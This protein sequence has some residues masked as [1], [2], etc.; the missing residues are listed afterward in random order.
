MNSGHHLNID[1][2]KNLFDAINKMDLKSIT[3]LLKTK[4]IDLKK[5]FISHRHIWRN[6]IPTQGWGDST[7]SP[8][9]TSI[10]EFYKEHSLKFTIVQSLFKIALANKQYNLKLLYKILKQLI[11]HDP[12]C[13]IQP[14]TMGNSVFYYFRQLSNIKRDQQQLMNQMGQTLSHHYRICLFH[15]AITYACSIHDKG[16]P[17][18]KLPEDIIYL[19]LYTLND[20]IKYLEKSGHDYRDELYKSFN[21]V[22]KG[23]ECSI[24]PFNH[25]QGVEI[26]KFMWIPDFRIALFALFHLGQ[27][28]KYHFDFPYTD[29][30][31]KKLCEL[32]NQPINAVYLLQI[33]DKTWELNGSDY[34][35][36]L[37]IRHFIDDWECVNLK[38]LENYSPNLCHVFFLAD[39]H[40]RPY[41]LELKASEL[42]QKN[43]ALTVLQTMIQVAYQ[44]KGK[45]ESLENYLKTVIHYF[46]QHHPSSLTERD[47]YGK[48]IY[49]Y[50]NQLAKKSPNN[51]AAV[52]DVTRLIKHVRENCFTK[53]GLLFFAKSSPLRTMPVEVKQKIAGLTMRV[54]L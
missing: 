51:Q 25:D 32:I 22:K 31:F 38:F 35:S 29:R 17:L 23:E 41:I 2:E 40:T 53:T 13:L 46:I 24:I 26:F 33:L 49:F 45:F 19:I 36:L 15:S 12:S 8:T 28:K 3:A 39:N 34:L 4:K 48:D 37:K 44:A 10:F 9:I 54:C 47:N 43:S 14:D 30:P 6:G 5:Q 42:R 50:L 20:T 11:H 7:D 18:S 16:S 21:S 1:D 52:S 27:I